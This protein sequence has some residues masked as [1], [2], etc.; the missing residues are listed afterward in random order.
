M[1][2]GWGKK[3]KRNTMSEKKVGRP[4]MKRGRKSVSYKQM[5]EEYRDL[6]AINE[7][8]F[9][10]IKDQEERLTK[11]EIGIRKLGD[12]HQHIFIQLKNHIQRAE[13]LYAE[14]LTWRDLLPYVALAAFVAAILVY[15]VRYLLF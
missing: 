10:E 9:K 4:K 3:A 13:D 7:W 2:I 12:N 6:L 11:C 15:I 8:C 5:S 14:E 1:C